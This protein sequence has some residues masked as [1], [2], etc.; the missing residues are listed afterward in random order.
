MLQLGYNNLWYNIVEMTFNMIHRFII[1]KLCYWFVSVVRR[2]RAAISLFLAEPSNSNP[3]LPAH[4]NKQVG[5]SHPYPIYLERGRYIF[6][7]QAKGKSVLQYSAVDAGTVVEVVRIVFSSPLC[8]NLGRRLIAVHLAQ[9]SSQSMIIFFL[10]WC[11]GILFASLKPALSWIV[12][13]IKS[14]PVVHIF[15]GVLSFILSSCFL[16]NLTNVFSTLYSFNTFQDSW[17]LK[18][19]PCSTCC[20]SCWVN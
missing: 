9:N 3:S 11:Y 13:E 18:Q 20:H 6:F 19:L 17:V 4:N 16:F 1:F 14:S 5:Q 8:F 10:G 15:C 7:N 2:T 12:S